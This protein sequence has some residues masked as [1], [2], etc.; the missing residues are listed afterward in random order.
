MIPVGIS[1]LIP[2]PPIPGHPGI[3][4]Y[5]PVYVTYPPYV[6][7]LFT[8]ILDPD[9]ATPNPGGNS[10]HSPGTGQNQSQIIEGYGSPIAWWMKSRSS[11]VLII[12]ALLVK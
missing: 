12:R 8:Y 6:R 9:P 4:M 1:I 11:A 7:K 2:S 5:L 10:H 3:T